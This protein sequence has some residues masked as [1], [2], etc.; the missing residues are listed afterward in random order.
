MNLVVG[1]YFSGHFDHLNSEAVS[2]SCRK[3]SLVIQFPRQMST[4]ERKQS[5]KTGKTATRDPWIK[6]SAEINEQ[7]TRMSLMCVTG[8]LAVFCLSEVTRKSD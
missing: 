1:D 4:E 8:R 6:L 3:G 5:W 2:Q 7:L